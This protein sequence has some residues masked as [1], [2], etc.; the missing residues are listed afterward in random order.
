MAALSAL[1]L[2]LC[3]YLSWHYLLGGTVIG[4]GGGSTA[5]LVDMARRVSPVPIDGLVDDWFRTT[6]WTAIVATE[7]APALVDRYRRHD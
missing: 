6:R 3:A 2:A 4:C 7:D 1:A 5:R